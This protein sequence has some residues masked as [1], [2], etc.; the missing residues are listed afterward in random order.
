M[1]KTLLPIA[2]LAMV[3]C[4]CQKEQKL[5]NANQHEASL[6]AKSN[7]AG[8]TIEGE[9]IIQL[10]SDIF[11]PIAALPLDYNA[12]LKAAKTLVENLL[13]L[14]PG[15][16]TIEIQRVFVT[17]VNGFSAKLTNEQVE[18]ISNLTAVVS[19]EE[20]VVFQLVGNDGTVAST[21]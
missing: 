10:Q 8:T 4:S 19:V 5:I 7:G 12:K 11:A 20:N 3:F 14:V 16:N 1:K 15:A 6:V 9:Y 13:A 18:A 21:Q 17:V 2:L